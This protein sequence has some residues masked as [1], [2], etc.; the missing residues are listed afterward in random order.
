MVEPA[1]TDALFAVALAAM[2]LA[3]LKAVR[4]IG[5]VETVALLVYL[6]FTLLS[7]SFGTI[8]SQFGA[9]RAAGV[10]VYLAL[11]FLM[12]AYFARVEGDRAFRMIML[13]LLIGG[14][15][16]SI[17]GLLAYADLLPN[18]AIFFRDQYRT[19]IQSTFKDP[20]V[21]GPY[22]VMSI[23]FTFWVAVAVD[24]FRLLAAAA[25]GVML[26]CLVVTF[27]RGAWIHMLVTMLLFFFFLLLF[28]RTALPTLITGV[29]TI[30][31]ILLIGTIF[32]EDIAESA[33][34]SYLGQ[35]LSLQ[36]YDDDRFEAIGIGFSFMLENPLGV[37]PNQ[38]KAFYGREPH[39]T[40]VIL[41][42]NNGIP[43]ALGFLVLYLA[44]CYRCLVKTLRQEDGWLKYA[45][46]LSIMT[47]LFILMNVVG[48]LHWRHLYVLI[49]LAYGTYRS[50]NIFVNKRASRPV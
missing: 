9:L 42:I 34:D 27:S 31:T 32:G 1:P 2:M 23:L 12:T 18:N 21:L 6:W 11:L 10:E 43:A 16:T 35:R 33:S 36:S 50:N 44:A 8:V 48:S 39:N 3:K 20:N 29:A 38:S 46:L 17:V 26:L 41:A 22:L 5:P 13:M 30:M 14:L 37:G 45:F 4:V 7:L 49:G 40:F 25:G 47:G 24:R 19:R 15:M 28:R